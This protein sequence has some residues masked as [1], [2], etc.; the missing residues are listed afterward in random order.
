MGC[1][2]HGWFQT[3]RKELF[4]TFSLTRRLGPGVCM[5]VLLDNKPQ[6]PEI[7]V[8][9]QGPVVQARIFSPEVSSFPKELPEAKEDHGPA[10]GREAEDTGETLILSVMSINQMTPAA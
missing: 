8:I 5:F 6:C 1:S 10:G 2:Y 7:S 3:R 9:G 4:S